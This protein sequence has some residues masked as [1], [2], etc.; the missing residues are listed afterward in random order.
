MKYTFLCVISVLLLHGCTSPESSWQF[1]VK[2]Y[3]ATADGETLTT[4]AIQRAIDEAHSKGG[5]TVYF[6]PGK[7]LTGTL[8]FKDKVSIHFESGA[9]LIGSKRLEDYPGEKKSLIVGDNLAD[10][11]V[12]GKGIINGN[13]EAFWDENYKALERP[14]PWIFLKNC[15]NLTIEG[16]KFIQSPSHVIRLEDSEDVT[17][18]DIT[19]IN[20]FRG[21]NTDGIDIVDSKYVTISNSFISTGDDAIC[22]KTKDEFVEHVV[23]TNCILESDDAAIKF[24]TGSKVGTRFCTFSNITINRTRY[25]ISLFMLDGGIYEHNIF[26]NLTITGGSRHQHEYPIFI[27]IDKRVPDRPYGRVRDNIFSNI[28]IVSSGKILVAGHPESKIEELEFDNISFHIIENTDFSSARKPRGNKNYPK[29]ETSE[30]LSPENGTFVFGHIENLSLT[31]L[32]VTYEEGVSS[33]RPVLF[34]KAIDQLERRDIRNI[35]PN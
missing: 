21:P 32:K 1:N 6:P 15:S 8:I 7:Y 16:I 14:E 2:D 9:E 30:D 10:V 17:F 29:L 3:G 13:G 35:K 23:V 22:L 28:K 31:D 33:E 27:D 12:S 18:D 20:D 4:A 11:K 19:I 5:G 26:S 25:G 34:T 24:G